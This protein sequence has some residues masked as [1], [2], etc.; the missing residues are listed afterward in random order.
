L[1]DEQDRT[2]WI[3]GE[4]RN[5]YMSVR[6]DVLMTVNIK[7]TLFLNKKTIIF[8]QHFMYTNPRE[9]MAEDT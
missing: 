7:S 9:E 3:H 2:C 1:E 8:S 4:T 5:E 6:S